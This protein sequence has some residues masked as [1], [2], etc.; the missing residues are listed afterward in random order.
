MRL[1][2]AA[3]AILLPSVAL[4]QAVLQGGPYTNGHLPVYVGTGQS[5]PVIQDAGPAGGAPGS[6][7]I[8]EILAVAPSAPTGPFGTNICDTDALVTAPG[9][10]HFLCFSA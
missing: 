7:G 3:L 2:L 6:T 1:R 5:S 4:A 9:G 8:S 10:Y